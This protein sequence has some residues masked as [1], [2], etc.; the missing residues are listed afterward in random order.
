MVY[1]CDWKS[2]IDRDETLTDIKWLFNNYGPY[3]EDLTT[4]ATRDPEFKVD[5]TR[6]NYGAPKELIVFTGTSKP[7][8]EDKEKEIV[9]FVIEKTKSLYWNDFINLIYST[10]PIITRPRYDYLD[11]K[12]LAAEY[13]SMLSARKHVMEAA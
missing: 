2:A 6:N 13:K 5:M 4:L 10:Y 1:L 9:D 3:V 11:L 12:E 8:L 7:V